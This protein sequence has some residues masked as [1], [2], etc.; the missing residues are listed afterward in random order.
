MYELKKAV[1]CKDCG[2][3]NAVCHSV[4][5]KYKAFKRSC[6]EVNRARRLVKDCDDYVVGRV[7][8][9]KDRGE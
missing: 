9:M 1:P 8:A 6:E 3:R 2:E 7:I 5:E 4:C